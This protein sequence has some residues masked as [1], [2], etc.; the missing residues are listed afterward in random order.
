MCFWLDVNSWASA[1]LTAGY[2]LKKLEWSLRLAV[3]AIFAMQA[4][5]DFFRH[6]PTV[7]LIHPSKIPAPFL[8]PA[9]VSRNSVKFV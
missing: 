7:V 9:I 3:L 1:K 6:V 2:G 8:L 4:E 5:H